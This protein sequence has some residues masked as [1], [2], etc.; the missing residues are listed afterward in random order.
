MIRYV[1]RR[2]LLFIP[3]LL[4]IIVIVQVLIT[5][6]PGDP[7]RIAA[8]I[9]PQPGE[10]ERLREEMGLD[11]PIFVQV[12]NFISHVVRGDLGKS[13][14]SGRVIL[15]DILMRWSYT[16]RL[17]V[18]SVTLSS[19][20]GI[21][22]GVFAATHQYKI[23]DNIAVLVSLIA[24]S[25][26]AFWFALLLVR[27]F[28]VQLRLLPVSGINSVKGWIMPVVSLSLGF[29]ASITR[30][31]RSNMLEVVRQDFI[32]TA[33]AKGQTERKVLFKHALKNALIPVVQVIGGIFGMALGGALI[34]EMIFAVP[35]LGMFSLAG[36]Q[37]RDY[38]VVKG[39]VLFLSTLF[40]V[41]MLLVDLAFAFI[42]PRIRA[43]FA[44]KRKAH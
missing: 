44:R 19:L 1:V 33:R 37:G 41:I 26:P 7:A 31:M 25:M 5:I 32:T 24:V 23:S 35:G 27:L 43:Q 34:T 9:E 12:W 8:G 40:C 16:V 15:D 3:I 18:M 22:L 6:A 2:L 20:I 17:A 30:Q 42:D 38:P 39:S 14:F 13:W 11:D 36:L 21:P 4:G 29:T 28:G 10:Y